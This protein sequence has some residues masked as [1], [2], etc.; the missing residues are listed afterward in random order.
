MTKHAAKTDDEIAGNRFQGGESAFGPKNPA[1]IVP[2]VTGS[3]NRQLLSEWIS[4]Q[5]DY[6]VVVTQPDSETLRQG[7]IDL[8][9][10]DR[11][12]FHTYKEALRER[13]EAEAPVQLPYLLL[14]PEGDPAV[15]E[16]DKGELI[17]ETLQETVDEIVSLPLK[18]AEL[19]WRVS[20]LLRIRSQSLDLTEEKERYE[21]LFTSIRDAIL[22][23][24]TDRRIINANPAF[25]EIFG[26]GLDEIKGKSTKY[27]L[28]SEEEFEKM[29]EAIESHIG[30]SEFTHT[31]T[32][33][34]RSGQTFPGKTNVFDL[35][36]ADGEIV[37]YIGVI[38]DVSDRENRLTQLQV[39]DRVLQ[40]NF[41]NDMNVIDGFAER[42]E[43]EV[44]PPLSNYAETIRKTGEDLLETV[45]KER[46]ITQFL[47]DPPPTKN[48]DATRM[49]ER[50]VDEISTRYPEANITPTYAGETRVV[51][52]VAIERAIEELAINSITHADSDAPEVTI[53]VSRSGEGPTISITDENSRIPDMERKVIT[54]EEELSS[55]YHGSGIGLWLVM[56]IVN[57]S[58]G[59]VKF[60]ENEPRG[61]TVEIC[62]SS[63]I[64]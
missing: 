33:E 26:Y 32:Y 59:V 61:N 31:V 37:G 15:I 45:E 50:V 44:S 52:S 51:A 10:L 57:H 8:C 49:I 63:R 55:V 28:E 3:G 58:D 25:T 54:G 12:A 40:H 46:E 13:K 5:P 1:R 18:K 36:N 19:G 20:A 29:G 17:D 2:L 62:L 4:E 39:I 60:Y 38:R 27:V 22:V 53:D 30:D 41:H 21:S 48:L 56:L 64:R 35:K 23:T 7:E 24:D 11:G 34:K 9:I 47:S 14:Y 16:S 42:I 6:E 43:S